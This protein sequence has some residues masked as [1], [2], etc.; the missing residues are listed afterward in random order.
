MPFQV[1]LTLRARQELQGLYDWIAD[2][3]PDGANRWADAFEEAI[4]RLAANPAGY[5]VAPESGS[6]PEVIR[7]FFF[8]T[9]RGW[10]YRA[11]FVVRGDRVSVLHI[12]GPGQRVMRPEEIESDPP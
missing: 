1:G 7:Q 5:G 12:R 3:S 2:R 6:S 11:L 8:K 10:T 4:E 9:R